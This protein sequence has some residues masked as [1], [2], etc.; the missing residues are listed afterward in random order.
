MGGKKERTAGIRARENE[1]E[2]NLKKEK[3]KDSFKRRANARE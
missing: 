2:R 3:W 1:N